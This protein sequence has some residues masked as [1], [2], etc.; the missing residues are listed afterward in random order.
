MNK[1]LLPEFSSIRLSNT[2]RENI[3]DGSISDDGEEDGSWD[4]EGGRLV[5]DCCDGLFWG[6]C[7]GL[8]W[9]GAGC[10]CGWDYTSFLSILPMI[11]F[12]YSRFSL[13]S[14]SISLNQS[15][16]LPPSKNV[17]SIYIDSLIDSLHHILYL[18]G[19]IIH[20]FLT[21]HGIL[22]CSKLSSLDQC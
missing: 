18:R 3:F 6:C 22:V 10:F 2:F 19:S 1:G 13:V 7:T 11:F 16:A 5:E 9:A 20:C 15:T 8:F 4:V 14:S 12:C 17:N 21:Q